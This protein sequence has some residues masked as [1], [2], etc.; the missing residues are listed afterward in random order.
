M[1]VMMPFPLGR[2]GR[3]DAVIEYCFRR[4][5]WVCDGGFVQ[6][7]GAVLAGAPSLPRSRLAGRG[8]PGGGAEEGWP[9]E[10]GGFSSLSSPLS[11]CVILRC[12][13]YLNR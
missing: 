8:E 4:P 5:K 11:N 12:S 13:Y 1:K 3:V 7:A 9:Q 10:V 6:P 2:S